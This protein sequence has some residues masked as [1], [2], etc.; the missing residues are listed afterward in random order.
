MKNFDKKYFD[1]ISESTFVIRNLKPIS[2]EVP[3]EDEIK[4]ALLKL[5]KFSSWNEFIDMQQ[6]G[7]CDKI[8]KTVCKLFPK[9]KMVSAY[10]NFSDVAI[11]EL[12][13]NEENNAIHYFN[14]IGKK[15]VDFGKGTNRY[16]GIY[17]LKGI[18]DL[19][20]VNFSDDALK[21]IEDIRNENPNS[22]GVTLR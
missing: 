8:A 14:K 20:D 11:L 9:V 22:I 21:M 10:I 12:N 17:I 7:Q 15:F 19:Y 13:D 3:A 18:D 6:T 16:K 1:I 2:N 5:Y 4:A